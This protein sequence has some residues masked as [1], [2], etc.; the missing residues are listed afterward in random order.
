MRK[1]LLTWLA[2]LARGPTQICE[3]SCKNLTL[4]LATSW[5]ACCLLTLYGRRYGPTGHADPI[6]HADAPSARLKLIQKLHHARKSDT[7]M[8]AKK[9]ALMRLGGNT[10]LR[11]EMG[12]NLW[13]KATRDL[14]LARKSDAPVGSGKNAITRFVRDLLRPQMGRNPWLVSIHLYLTRQIHV[15]ITKTRRAFR[16]P[17]K[18]TLLRSHISHRR[19][20]SLSYG[21]LRPQNDLFIAK[22]P[23]KVIRHSSGPTEKH[24]SPGRAILTALALLLASHTP[25]QATNIAPGL[26][27]GLIIVIGVPN[28]SS[29]SVSLVRSDTGAALATLTAATYNFDSPRVVNF[30]P[31]GSQIWVGNQGTTNIGVRVI[32]PIN[33][34]LIQSVTSL[35]STNLSGIFD[36]VFS[37]DGTKAYAT[38]NTNGN[39]F[40]INTSDRTSFA[41]PLSVGAGADRAALNTAGDRLFVCAFTANQVSVIDTS[42]NTTSAT[43]TQSSGVALNGPTAVATN[44]DGTE[45]YFTQLSG[46]R[47]SRINTSNISNAGTTTIGSGLSNPIGIAFHPDSTTQRGYLAPHAG[48]GLHPVNTSTDT[49]GAVV[50]SGGA[51]HSVAMSPEG[52]RAYVSDTSNSRFRVFDTSTATLTNPGPWITVGSTPIYLCTSPLYIN[53]TYSVGSDATLTSNGFGLNPT[54]GNFV[55]F[56]GGTLQAS[57]S[58]STAK[59]FSFVGLNGIGS[60]GT[61]NTNGFNVTLN[62][63]VSGSQ[64]FTK[65]GTGTLILNA[66]NTY[67]GSTTISGG[68]LRAGSS[69]ALGNNSALTVGASGTLD[70]NGQTL[71][72]GSLAGSAGGIVTNSSA[73]LATLTVGGDNTNTTYSGVLQNGTGGLNLTKTGT[74]ILTL[75]GG[76]S[77]YTGTI[78]VN[79]G[80]L[81]QGALNG[82][83]GNLVSSSANTPSIDLGNFN[84]TLLS[85]NTV[86]GVTVS[87]TGVGTTLTLQGD[88]TVVDGFYG[89]GGLTVAGGTT[90]LGDGSVFSG[91]LYNNGA[92]TINSG[93][94]LRSTGAV[95]FDPSKTSNLIING[96][97]TLDNIGDEYLQNPLSGSGT[98]NVNLN[99]ITSS[100]FFSGNS[101]TFSGTYNIQRG[102]VVANTAINAF[103][104]TSRMNL[105]GGANAILN[106]NGNSISIGSLEGTAGSIVNSGTAG[107]VTLT[108]GGGNR[109]TTFAGAIQNGSG[110]IALTKTG[111]GL[112]ILTGTNTY[113]G[114]TT[115][116]GGTLQIGN[117]NSASTLGSGTYSGAISIASGA[118]LGFNSSSSQTLSGVIIGTGGA[119]SKNGTG[120]LTLSNAGNTY[121]GGTV[122]NGGTISIAADAPLGGTSSSLYF[123]GGTLATTATFTLSGTRALSFGSA[124]GIFAPASGTTLT[125][126]NNISGSGPLT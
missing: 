46:G 91:R 42:T 7:P 64:S 118:T 31:D 59:P 100:K 110:T 48:G 11:A 86:A 84:T 54:R 85:L 122:L 6:K 5:R 21:Q 103:G 72:A 8:G 101:S 78:T 24:K 51:T 111:T 75:S 114:S 43:I 104:S 97:L 69:T 27:S 41:T 105:S 26:A 16:L 58:F 29:N 34:T 38:G 79:Q 82:I 1:T 60:G 68:T 89:D 74:G 66:A 4:H 45:I 56:A 62:G 95:L 61:I 124:G 123:D 55:N 19:L 121:S 73:S 13:F 90:T 2:P 3:L 10:L 30:S 18:N 93:A 71:S 92:T 47:L 106:L 115:I 81:I 25:S 53:G 116:S 9:S 120:T 52:S 88:S 22:N 39:L 117:A 50:S 35:N 32:N 33:N 108:M 94:T 57:A 83:R 119:L 112:Q 65:S 109:D 44:P 70:V 20:Q 15:L 67:S 98:L 126:N 80:D 76:N 63:R 17:G 28:I 77:A 99:S 14:N 36:V 125:V 37:Q 40:F 107:A 49:V 102:R 23:K 96:I 87:I 12:S 113:T